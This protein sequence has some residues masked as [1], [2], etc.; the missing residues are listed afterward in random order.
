MTASTN[1]ILV[2][3]DDGEM[4][5]RRGVAYAE[6][7]TRARDGQGGVAVQYMRQPGDPEPRTE[8]IENASLVGV[9]DEICDDYL[10]DEYS[11]HVEI[12]P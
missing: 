7:A 10:A 8:F 6:E 3:L 5:E 12:D 1:E 2:K 4:R 9:Y 11:N